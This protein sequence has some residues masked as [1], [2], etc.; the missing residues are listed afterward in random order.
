MLGVRDEI[1]E[2]ATPLLRQLMGLTYAYPKLMD[3]ADATVQIGR[4]LR[5]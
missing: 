1:K 2:R 4:D 3:E 5:E